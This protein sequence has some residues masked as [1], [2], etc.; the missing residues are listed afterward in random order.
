MTERAGLVYAPRADG[1]VLAVWNRRYL[2]WGLP[3]GECYP[4]ED[5]H[6]CARRELYEEAGILLESI[7]REPIDISPT[8]TGSGR[9]CHT[10]R[11]WPNVTWVPQAREVGTG[12]AW[13]TREFLC[14]QNHAAGAWFREF[15]ARVGE[16]PTHVEDWM[17]SR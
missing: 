9:A 17:H 15:F 5:P 10:Y 12:V 8:Y 16:R 7:S 3:G 4:G 11:A 1:A 13:M 2:C 6:W 14:A